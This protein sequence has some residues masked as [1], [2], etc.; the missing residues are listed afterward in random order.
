[1]RTF[2]LIATILSL[3]TS[4]VFL[5]FSFE[6]KNG[7]G[8]TT[9]EQRF[10]LEQGEDMF[11]VAKRLQETGIISS[12]YALLW[13][14]VREGKT[15]QLVAGTYALRGDFSV[16]EII[17]IITKGMVVPRDIKI[18][19]PEGWDARQMAERLT[20]HSLPGSAFLALVEKPKEEW[21]ER[22]IFLHNIPQNASLEG[23]LFPDT[24]FF[25]PQ[26][27]AEAIIEKMLENFD[28]KVDTT[29]KNEAIKRHG[30][31]FSALILASIVE[32]EVRSAED[33]A[34]VSDLFLRRLASGQ[35]LESDATVKYILG[36]DKIQHTFA[37]TRTASPYNTYIHSGL[38]PGPIGNPGLVSLRS[39]IYPQ[40]NPYFY[41]LSD[42]KTGETVFSIT[43]EEH[44]RNKVSHGL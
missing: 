21:R 1:M 35:A 3:L 24:Y 31:F 22:F 15:K 9:Q 30:D 37:E 28:T 43:Y 6:I 19:F 42:P 2:L 13:Q 44:L 29:L 10:V 7:R 38:P 5:Y 32:N 14:L 33:R 27:S 39:A 17:M 23:F 12:R 18:T 8:I 26:T 16:A 4:G 11:S 34:L 20:A 40:V 25:Y 36:I 41:F